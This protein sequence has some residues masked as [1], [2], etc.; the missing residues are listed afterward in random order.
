MVRAAGVHRRGPC[1][2]ELTSTTLPQSVP[3]IPGV[4]VRVG[5]PLVLEGHPHLPFDLLKIGPTLRPVV[6]RELLHLYVD[7][8][9]GLPPSM[10][11]PSTRR[12][13]PPLTQ[14]LSHR[15]SVRGAI[16]WSCSSP[17]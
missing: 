3:A 14:R 9:E 1:S 6:L 12:R 13:S 11:R 2:A 8:I 17:S 16:L 10:A 7:D 5:D 15:C 4:Q